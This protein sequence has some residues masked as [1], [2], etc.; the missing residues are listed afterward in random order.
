MATVAHHDSRSPARIDSG[1]DDRVA[2]KLSEAE[3]LLYRSNL[4]GADKQITNFGGGNTSAKLQ[5]PDPLTGATCTVL[6]VKGS[7]GDLGSMKLDGFST[8]YLDKLEALR[9]RYR[10]LAHEDEMVGYLPH[11]TFN[12]NPRAASIDTPLHS[13]LPHAHVDHMHPDAVIAIAASRNSRDLTAKVFGGDIGWLP[14]Q[15]PGFDLGLR[16][17]ELARAQPGLKGILLEAHGIFTWG[18]SSRE[19]YENTLA[20]V[21]RASDWL[22]LNN[23]R[24]AFGGEA[25][26]ALA[27]AAR[28]AIVA[29][30]MPVLRGKLSSRHYKLGHFDA[31]ATVLEF[32][33]SRQLH[34]LAALG[35]SCPDHFLRTKIRPLVLDF[36]PQN[37]DL[38]RLL[39]QLDAALSAYRADYAAY[40]ERCKRPNS[41]AMRDADPVVFL[42]PG[43]GILTFA[44]D[45]PT[46]RIA[47]E[48]YVN[49][50]NVMRGASGVDTYVGLPEQEAFDIEYWLLEQA[51]LDRMP[52]PRSLAGRVALVTGAA[53]GIGQA[54]CRRLLADGACLVLADID[55]AAL[56]MAATTLRKQFGSDAVQTVLVDVTN[57]AA[58]D[59]AIGKAALAF[60]GLDILVSNAGI[61]SSAAFEDTS[62]QLWNQNLAV[63]ATGYFLVSRAA[64]RLL[65]RQGLGGSIVYVG[66]KNAIAASANAAAYCTAKA[67]ELHLARC[68]ALEGATH[69][70]R[71]NV[72]NPDAVLRGSRIWNGQWRAER[73]EAYNL[74]EDDL[75]EF[76]RKRSMLKLGVYPE[77]VAEAVAFFASDSSA[78]STG[79]IVNVDA[80]NASAFTR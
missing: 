27:P 10:G 13:F 43:V 8:L 25:R 53:G 60:G 2:S 80:G 12:L 54:V 66:S 15:R 31:S 44:R 38:D 78:K 22:Q 73:A 17:A 46:A 65:I 59:A 35:T 68:L 3:L 63:L 71:V 28:D 23:T 14:W 7:G 49:A 56:D 45:K 36:D 72:V 40:Y 9:A 18:G 77:D 30:L 6:W 76:Y 55:A 70:I 58:V 64:Y 39:A 32:V 67:A 62:L 47:A 50:I 48:F 5:M 69:G 20:V 29:N 41:P 21:R 51:K 19:C 26:S 75:E 4:L 33:C 74:K 37:P 16:L 11:C 61:A 79:N 57:E 52:K 1:W 42:L 34:E 24:A